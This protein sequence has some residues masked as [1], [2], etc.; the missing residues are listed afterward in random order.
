MS[1]DTAYEVDGLEALEDIIMLKLN[2]ISSQP[3]AL[4]K[5]DIGSSHLMADLCMRNISEIL[6]SDVPFYLER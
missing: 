6:A 4:D 5:A 2:H 1:N 3:S